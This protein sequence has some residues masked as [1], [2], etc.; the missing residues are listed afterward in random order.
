MSRFTKQYPDLCECKFDVKKDWQRTQEGLAI[1]PAQVKEL[2]DRG[3]PV[4]AQN[5][6]FLESGS[7]VNSWIVE[8]QFR[9]EMDMATAWEMEKSA[10]RKVL[11]TLRQK[12]F[13]DKYVNPQNN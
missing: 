4:S 13:N 5:V 9:R 10:S 12:K 3:I 8:P 11:Q 1:T 7:D 6:N 2:T